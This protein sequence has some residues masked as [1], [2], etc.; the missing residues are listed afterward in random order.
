M[1]HTGAVMS[2]S[3]KPKAKLP[4]SMHVALD[5]SDAEEDTAFAT[6]SR[7]RNNHLGA[8]RPSALVVTNAATAAATVAASM[9]RPQ[10]PL[11]SVHCGS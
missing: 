7:A 6:C 8:C 9:S 11:R 10:A 1:G 4:A 5:A 2:P 3:T